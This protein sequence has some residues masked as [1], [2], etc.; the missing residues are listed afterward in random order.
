MRLDNQ[1][2]GSAPVR[3]PV[4]GR[5][6]DTA[7]ASTRAEMTV[8]VHARL[9]G[10][11]SQLGELKV[12]V[13]QAQ[14]LASLGTAAA[15]IAHEVNNALT[16]MLAFAQ[17]ALAEDDS[18]LQRK[19][20][21]TTVKSVRMLVA[22]SQRVLEIGAAK[23]PSIRTVYVRQAALDAIES[24]CRDL[25]KDGI[26]LLLNVDESAAVRADELQLRQVLFNLFLNARDAM[27]SSHN[28]RLIVSAKPD[29][30]DV[31]IRVGDTGPGISAGTIEHIFDPLHTTK[32]T[33]EK[34][35]KRCAGL[36]LALCRDLVEE[37]GG[38]IS[39]ESEPGRGSTF[40]IRLRAAVSATAPT[41]TPRPA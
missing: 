31:L 10:L 33:S 5:N 34:T 25:S 9:E 19:A 21:E 26:R 37:N 40:T 41:A 28:G 29:G 22:M 14:Q 13:R 17:A 30:Q 23:P 39:V 20:L 7:P 16:P 1:T 15:V 18:A 2:F 11:E 24:L 12:R 36:G 35:S 3:K 38:T 27:A 6:G 8:D 4:A 32:A